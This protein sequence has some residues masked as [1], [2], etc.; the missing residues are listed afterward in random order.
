MGEA[1]GTQPPAGEGGEVEGLS[2]ATR[3]CPPSVCPAVVKPERLQKATVQLLDQALCSRLYGSALTDR[4][5]CAGYLDGK[6]DSCQVG[7][8]QAAAPC[9]SEICLQGR[10]WMVACTRLGSRCPSAP[11]V[12]RGDPW[13]A[14]SPREG[15]SWPAS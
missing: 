10:S 9:S 1:R 15:S 4:M 8:G 2:W 12:T 6:V 11:R 7:R 5:L 14:R 13:C 3:P